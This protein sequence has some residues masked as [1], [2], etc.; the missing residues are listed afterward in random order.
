MISE[1]RVAQLLG[2]APSPADMNEIHRVQLAIQARDDDA[3][4]LVVIALQSHRQLL[5][6]FPNDLSQSISV[7]TKEAETTARIQ[8]Q[9]AASQFQ[10]EFSKTAAAAAQKIAVH[11]S[12]R[13][14]VKWLTVGAIFI[15]SCLSLIAWQSHGYGYQQ[16]FQIGL[17]EA[18]DERAAASWANT[19]SGRAAYRLDRAGVLPQLLNCGYPGWHRKDVF[20]YPGKTPDGTSYGYRLP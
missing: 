2:Q 16:G 10:S 4:L 18:R 20:C 3:I 9:K 19:E 5:K 12:R 6:S 1:T 15:S 7:I 17:R 11:V 13:S 14:L 8:L